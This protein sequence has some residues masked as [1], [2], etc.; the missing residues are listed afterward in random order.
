MIECKHYARGECGKELCT[1]RGRI[2]ERYEPAKKYAAFGWEVTVRF[3]PGSR[4]PDATFHWHGLTEAAARRKGMLKTNA[5]EIL[6]VEPVTEEQ[7]IRA[8]G[9]PEERGL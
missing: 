2:C 8:Y 7:W 4:K 1:A 5:S 6:S 9:N 3:A